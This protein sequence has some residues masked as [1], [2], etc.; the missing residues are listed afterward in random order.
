MKKIILVFFTLFALYSCSD[1]VKK[2]KQNNKLPI[3]LTTAKGGKFYGETLHVNS[4]EPI[5]ALFPASVTDIYSQHVSS[6][7]YEGLLKFDPNDLSIQ[8]A[9]A[10][11]YTIDSLNKKYRFNIRKNVYFHNDP[12]FIDGKGRMVTAKDVKYVFEF[13][14]SNHKMNASTIQWRT[15]ILGANDYF[16]NKTDHV[17]GIKIIDDFC[18][19]I[20]LNEPFS[21]FLNLLALIHT[22]IFPKEAFEKY[23][24]QLMNEMAIGTGPFEVL[25]IEDTFKLRK[26]SHYWRKDEFGN[27]LPLLSYINIQFDQ[28]K[29][30]ELADFKKGELDFIWGLPV[31]EIPNVIGSLEDAKNGKNKEFTVQSINSLQV[32][33]Y[34]FLMKDSLLKNKALRKALNYAVNKNYIA[35]YILEGSALPATHGIIPTIHGYPNANVKGYAFSKQKA[36]YYLKRAGYTNGNQVKDLKLYYNNSGQIIELVA[37]SIQKQISNILNIDLQLVQYERKDLFSKIENSVLPFWRFGWIADYPDP[38]NFIASFHSKNINSASK[39][40]NNYGLYNNPEFDFYFDKAMSACN[41]SSR[42]LDLAMAENILMEDAAVLPL[43]YYT[44][45]RLINPQLRD[46]P[47]NE[48]EY[49]DYSLVYFTKEKKKRVRVY[50]SLSKE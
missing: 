42:M 25:S 14:C 35:T 24:P 31:E 27:Q 18:I 19:E 49:R 46:F 6:Q 11:S 41:D 3:T 33:Y 40:A 20:E 1:Q 29:S 30:N 26:N 23:G 10:S 5:T 12:C 28:N 48:L 32:E 16:E 34:G 8:P 39:S 2:N 21:G 15:S 47:I 9:I 38:A 7:I 4:S 22:S 45:I 37:N 13:L 50:E 17:A 43:F 44:S 36:L